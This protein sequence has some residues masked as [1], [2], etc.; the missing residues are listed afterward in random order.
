MAKSVS[1][2]QLPDAFHVQAAVGWL[3]LSN[4]AEAK[5]EL[6]QLPAT[7]REHPDALEVW[8]KVFAEGK[9]WA[10]ALASAEKLVAL[11]PDRVSGWVDR[12]YALHELNRTKDAYDLLSPLVEK[13]R[14]HY[15]IPYNL[16]C[17]QCE[18]GNHEA[19]LRWLRCAV[20][21]SDL[22][23]IR[24]MAAQDPDLEPLRDMIARLG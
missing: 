4:V 10:G 7:L 22:K 2:L 6:E 23:T 17:Y 19:A 20:E 11:A 3:E 1:P 9:D 8:W 24:S 14:E 12:S 13:F 15:V 5:L 21:A 16:A 18:L